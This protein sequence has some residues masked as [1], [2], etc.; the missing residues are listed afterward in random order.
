VTRHRPPTRSAQLDALFTCPLIHDLAADLGTLG[1]RSRR[2]PV[3]F[4][5]AFGAMSR[6]FGSG[7]RLD[8]ELADPDTWASMVER[9]NKGAALHLDG[10]EMDPD[11]PPL[12]ADTYRHV[13]DHLTTDASMETLLD[14]FTHHSVAIA[15]SVGLL[16][17][18]GPGSRTYPHP[19]RTIYGD[20][21]V[22][23]PLYGK[24]DHGRQDPDAE[25]HS[26]H[27]GKIYGNDLVAIATRGPDVA[28][29]V[30]LAVGRVHE[31]GHEAAEAVRLIKKVHAV[32]GEGIQAV[33]Y[34]GAF[35]G[36]HHD[37]LMTELGLVVVN[38]VHAATRDEKLRTYRQIPLGTWEH[39]VRGRTCTHTLVVANGSVHDSTMDDSGR[40]VLSDPL[41]RK[42]IRRFPRPKDAGWRFSLGVTVPCPKA[43]FTAWISPHREGGDRSN[44]RPD[45][46]RLIPEAD[47]YF[48]TL[49]GLRN[50]SESI[51][52]GYKRTLLVDRAAALGWR[53]QVL[54]LMSWSILVNA[55]AWRAAQV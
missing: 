37:T 49:Y 10:I 32:A 48:Q 53:R 26:R 41:A 4:H 24:A 38:K 5:L 25:E 31:R 51:N 2:H 7:N 47:D 13:R 46:L 9:Y 27:D 22:V 55:S 12:L 18:D 23:R 33:V 40:L 17:P 42:Q 45:Q 36:V 44:S 30:I 39:S 19:S 21:T 29:R 16:R 11:A 8:A 14:S 15:Q 28:Q 54:D 35:R 3:A 52:S 43:P 1:Q 50:D 20:G 34:D 6:L